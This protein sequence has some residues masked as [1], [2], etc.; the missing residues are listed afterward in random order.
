MLK[1][2]IKSWV[3]YPECGEEE[4]PL[5][6]IHVSSQ[7]RVDIR[8]IKEIRQGKYQRSTCIEYFGNKIP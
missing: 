1:E 4:P 5:E 6:R 2:V 3:P 8:T 7:I